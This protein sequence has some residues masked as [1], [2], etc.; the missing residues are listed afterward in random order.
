MMLRD[1]SGKRVTIAGLGHFGGNIA[2]AKWLVEQGAE[3][4]VTDR[5]P[6]DKLADSLAQLAGLPITFKLGGHDLADF[7][8][9]DLVVAS[10][11][12]PPSNEYL[13]AARLMGVPVTTEICLFLE[14][15]P[16]PVVGVTGT[17]GKST[18]SAMLGEILKRG[19]TTWFGG[20]IGK[21]LLPELPNI[22]RDHVVVLE[23]SSFMLHYTGENLWSPHVAVVTLLAP[24][25][26]DWHGNFDAYAE[27]KRNIVRFQHAGDIAVVNEESAALMAWFEERPKGRVVRYGVE[28]RRPFEL[29]I[30]GRH[31]Q[32]NAQGAFAAAAALGVSWDDAAAALGR[33]KGLPHRLQLVHEAGGVRWFND[34]IATIPEAAVAATSAFDPGRVIQIVGG[35]DKGLDITPMVDVLA[36]RTKAVLC[37]GTTGPS[38]AAQL[39][40]AGA[41]D[42]RECGDLTSAVGA[43]KEIAV[44]GDVVLLSTGFASYDQFTNFED[45]GEQFARLAL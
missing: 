30:P 20:N 2:A 38:V 42:V 24:D 29:L 5:A 44:A 26:L 27:A 9:V 23:L 10:P 6:A 33:Y 12:I 19:R 1:L 45:R 11:A 35:S 7:N 18:T 4:L 17:K 36:R 8:Q 43:A 22:Q 32:L 14:R 40:K 37:I 15:C 21:S 16:A 41:R 25:H 13:K 31:N 3:V 34:S 39:R 28:G